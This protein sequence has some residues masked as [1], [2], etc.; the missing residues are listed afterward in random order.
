MA[1]FDSEDEAAAAAEIAREIARVHMDSYGTRF[2]NVKVAIEEAFVAVV[3]DV[4]LSPAE[5]TLLEA[6]N[7]ESVEV[8]REAFQ[9]AI[10]PTFTAIV[11][12]ATGQRVIGFASRTVVDS[13]G[14]W[15]VEAFRLDGGAPA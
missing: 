14:A 9:T 3:A 11:E 2:D 8:G 6:G 7:A 15:A 10:A 12:R 4:E 13:A 1:R 5:R